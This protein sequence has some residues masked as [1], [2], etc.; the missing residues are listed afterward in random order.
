MAKLTWSPRSLNDLEILH[1][2]IKQDSEENAGDFIRQLI[3]ATVDITKFPLAGRKVPEY[4]EH[5]IREKLYKNYRI[6][7][8]INTDGIAV[9]TVL[10]QTRRLHK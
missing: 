1:E 6:I 8:R 9:L 5:R 2:Y 10:H 3:T 7:Y 4:K